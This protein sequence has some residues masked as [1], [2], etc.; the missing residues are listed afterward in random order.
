MNQ[1]LDSTVL[2]HINLITGPAKKELKYMKDHDWSE[3]KNIKRRKNMY[4][5][6]HILVDRN[7]NALIKLHNLASDN[8]GHPQVKSTIKLLLPFFHLLEKRYETVDKLFDWTKFVEEDFVKDEDS[9]G[10]SIESLQSEEIEFQSGVLKDL[11]TFKERLRKI[12]FGEDSK[13]VTIPIFGDT[14]IPIV[15][16]AAIENRYPEVKELVDKKLGNE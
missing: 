8:L 15:M 16:S 6:Q 11:S 12:N 13:V 4:D 10:R 3:V 1:E 14:P 5:L 9:K 2:D 7:I